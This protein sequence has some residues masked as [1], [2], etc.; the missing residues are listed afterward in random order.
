MTCVDMER[1]SSNHAPRFLTSWDG[2][3]RE[4]A[5]VRLSRWTLESC[6]LVPMTWNSVLASLMR[7]LLFSN[8]ARMSDTQDSMAISAGFSDVVGFGLNA[9]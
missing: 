7:R 6:C 2:G 9:R 3:I 8:H 4:E 1:V 5:I